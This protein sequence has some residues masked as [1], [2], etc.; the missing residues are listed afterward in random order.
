MLAGKNGPASVWNSISLKRSH[1]MLSPRTASV[2]FLAAALLCGQPHAQVE[3]YSLP[4]P[5][6]QASQASDVEMQIKG[7]TDTNPGN[8]PIPLDDTGFADWRFVNPRSPLRVEAGVLLLFINQTPDRVFEVT[9]Q[10][11]LN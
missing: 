1:D 2:A 5:E 11:S 10:L 8:L 7:R 6:G 9:T 3:L 4:A